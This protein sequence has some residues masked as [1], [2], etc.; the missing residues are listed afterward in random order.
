MPWSPGPERVSVTTLARSLAGQG[1]DADAIRRR[2][3]DTG[4]PGGRGRERA[5][6]SQLTQAISNAMRW[7]SRLDAAR[8]LMHENPNLP[9]SWAQRNDALPSRFRYHV[10][11]RQ[12][13]ETTLLTTARTI[14]IDSSHRLSMEE[15]A[16][17][18]VQVKRELDN[19]SERLAQLRIDPDTFIDLI[20]FERRGG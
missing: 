19:V 3:E 15:L 14:I 13:D 20:N 5:T 12:T 1:F 6:A 2:L 7:Q 11:F 8:E 4:A 9:S 16:A 10:M 17:Q 18:A